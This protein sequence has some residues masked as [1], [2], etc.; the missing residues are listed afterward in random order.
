MVAG[1]DQGIFDTLIDIDGFDFGLINPRK[2]AQI[3][4]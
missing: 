3:D 4:H 2:I 1:N